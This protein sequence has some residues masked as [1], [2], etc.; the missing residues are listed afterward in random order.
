ML[1]NKFQCLLPSVSEAAS[2]MLFRC[3]ATLLHGRT[4]LEMRAVRR[5]GFLK[6]V[7]MERDASFDYG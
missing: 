5:Q 4:E 2:G 1:L 3:G 6:P 7:V